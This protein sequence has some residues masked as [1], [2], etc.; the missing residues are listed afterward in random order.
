MNLFTPS[1]KRHHP[2]SSS[3]EEEE[4][5]E[6]EEKVLRFVTPSPNTTKKKITSIKITPRKTVRETLRA[7][8]A[9]ASSS[10]S[11]FP[12]PSPFLF[13]SPSSSSSPPPL[14]SSSPS[15]RALGP[16]K[17][18]CRKLQTKEFL[19]WLTSYKDNNC[20][21]LI[22]GKP[23]CGKSML[24]EY[25]CF[26]AEFKVEKIYATESENAKELCDKLLWICS[27]RTPGGRTAV[28]LYDADEHIDTAEGGGGSGN[29]RKGLASQAIE[30]FVKHKS[31]RK[32]PLIVICNY[33]RNQQEIAVKVKPLVDFVL[34]V[35]PYTS[36]EMQE[37]IES[38]S[39]MPMTQ[40]EIDV[41]V[42]L[43]RGD[44]RQAILALN[45]YQQ[46]LEKGE[47]EK[48]DSCLSSWVRDVTNEDDNYKFIDYELGGEKELGR[49]AQRPAPS[50]SSSASP[51]P[52][53]AAAAFEPEVLMMGSQ[54]KP[55]VHFTSSSDEAIEA[56]A[57]GVMTVGRRVGGGGGAGGARSMATL[58]WTDEDEDVEEE[59]D[60]QEEE[61]EEEETKKKKKKSAAGQKKKNN[62]KATKTTKLPASY[63]ITEFLGDEDDEVPVLGKK[64]AEIASKQGGGKS[65]K[66]AT[67][68]KKLPIVKE[69]QEGEEEEEEEGE[70]AISLQ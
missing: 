67:Q 24:A 47:G 29:S 36:A 2:S 48:K 14:S 53:A 38:S 26:A 7:N 66:K 58:G 5:E 13:S 21:A 23:G 60:D 65:T 28:L 12:S 49:L 16:S 9:L 37:I 69:E 62:K 33:L 44:A 39:K 41:I 63:D 64:V 17:P 15:P 22:H 4:E 19:D 1:R 31:Q 59:G 68:K 32:S 10:S 57:G 46:S 56:T 8:Q 50:S 52:V 20:V 35:K 25:C 45:F 11:P 30:M 18:R 3:E 61:E 70:D 51:E 40:D 55:V 34:H 42:K 6:K 54:V 43:A 27:T